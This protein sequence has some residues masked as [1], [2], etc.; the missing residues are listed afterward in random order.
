MAFLVG[1]RPCKHKNVIHGQWKGNITAIYCKKCGRVIIKQEN[2]S[3][4][5]KDKEDYEHIYRNF[6]S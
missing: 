4:S 6:N 5:K 3:V 2:L 1:P